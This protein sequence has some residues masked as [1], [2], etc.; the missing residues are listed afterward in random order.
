MRAGG[1]RRSDAAARSRSDPSKDGTQVALPG[2]GSLRVA[3]PWTSRRRWFIEMYVG[4]DAPRV[5]DPPGCLAA[6]DVHLEWRVE[7]QGR[8]RCGPVLLDV[9][10]AERGRPP[11]PPRDDGLWLELFV[12]HRPRRCRRIVRWAAGACGPIRGEIAVIETTINGAFSSVA[13]AAFTQGGLGGEAAH[14][15][16][17]VFAT[18]A[19]QHGSARI[20]GF[21]IPDVD[22]ERSASCDGVDRRE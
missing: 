19:R 3:A 6:A 15:G 14:C 5:G 4:W 21:D 10:S 13:T 17:R 18:F 20:S 7:P 1:S 22:A 8:G 12:G 11:R 2:S 16:P 9:R